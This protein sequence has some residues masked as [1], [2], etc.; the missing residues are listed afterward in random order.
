MFKFTGVIPSSPPD[1]SAV[2]AQP[3]ALWPPDHKLMEVTL[4][5]DATITAVTQDEPVHAIA[6]GPDAQRG[7]APN[8][9]LLRAEAS[10]AGDGRVYRIAFTIVDQ[11]GRSCTGTAAVA[12]PHDQSRPAVDSGQQFNSFES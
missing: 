3:S 8:R 7:A 1:C 11:N 12:V 5:A 10:G 9:V 6:A 2:A 4:P